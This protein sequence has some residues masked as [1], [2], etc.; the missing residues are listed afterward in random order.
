MTEAS[1]GVPLSERKGDWFFVCVFAFFAWS[2]FF[3]DAFAGLGLIGEGGFWQR[4]NAWY[5]SMG[6]PFFGADHW[7]FRASP[8]TSAFVYG[9]FYLV[10]VYAIATGKNWVRL[11]AIFY[12]GMM[13]HGMMELFYWEFCNP[14]GQQPTNLAWFLGWNTPYLVFPLLFTVRVWKP[15]PFGRA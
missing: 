7:W 8:A 15:E 10:L 14:L 5:G 13:T 2:S 1:Q 3:S 4:A 11:P 12:V 9:P 6:D